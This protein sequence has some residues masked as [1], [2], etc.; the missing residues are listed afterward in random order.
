MAELHGK[1]H[2]EEEL[3]S[4]TVLGLFNATDAFRRPDRF[5]HF[6]LACEADARGRLGLELNPYPQ[7]DKLRAAFLAA[8]E[9][10]ARDLLAQG[11]E[12][13]AL[14]EALARERLKAVKSVRLG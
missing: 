2:R 8:S 4:K 1:V 13:P 9:V 3:R 10:S 11:I 12:G 5:E 7:A 6:L 14:G